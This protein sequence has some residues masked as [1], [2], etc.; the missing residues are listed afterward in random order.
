MLLEFVTKAKFDLAELKFDLAVCVF[1]WYNAIWET[2]VVQ[3]TDV[4]VMLWLFRHLP[5]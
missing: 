5:W 3:M 1:C 2:V 4:N